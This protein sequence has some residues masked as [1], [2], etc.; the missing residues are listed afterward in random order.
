MQFELN[1]QKQKAHDDSLISSGIYI[2]TQSNPIYTAFLA[3]P[4]RTNW[5]K[6][7]NATTTTTMAAA[8]EESLVEKNSLEWLTGSARFLKFLFLSRS[9][10]VVL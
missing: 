8:Q 2:T 4:S 5:R 6:Y 7:V 1:G 10:C 3:F 9:F